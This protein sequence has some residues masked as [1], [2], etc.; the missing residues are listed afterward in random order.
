VESENESL[1]VP[2]APLEH[3]GLPVTEQQS[4]P[5]KKK[6][7]VEHVEMNEDILGEDPLS[8]VAYTSE[9]L[10]IDM[11]AL[12]STVPTRQESLAYLPSFPLPSQPAP[13]S[14]S[15]LYLQGLDQALIEAEIVDPSQVKKLTMGQERDSFGLSF[16]TRQRLA[17]IGILELFAGIPEYLYSG[18]ARRSFLRSQ[19]KLLCYRFS[20]LR[21]HFQT[22]CTYRMGHHE[23]C[24][25]LLLL[26]AGKH[27]HTCFPS[28]R[29]VST[30]FAENL[31]FRTVGSLLSNSHTIKS[32][33]CSSYS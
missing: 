28:W 12:P 17:Q 21:P 20:S 26:G 27:W 25:F 14:A 16:K 13:P 18:W 30:P 3:E 32:S 31:L 7:K 22:D 2:Q 6:R 24:V 19:Y 33:C 9:T 11:E 23:M 8:P 5:H 1:G 10:D 15:V 4:R 29:W